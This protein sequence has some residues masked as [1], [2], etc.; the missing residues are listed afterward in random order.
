MLI[1]VIILTFN[2][3]LHIERCIASARDISD[4][5]YVIDSYSTDGTIRLAKDAGATVL[6]RNFDS[7]FDQFNWALTKIEPCEWVIRLDADEYFTPQLVESINLLRTLSDPNI[8][9]YAF[10]RRM[11]FLN[12]SIRFGGVF[13]IEIVRMFRFGNGSI[14]SRLMDEHIIVSG[15][16][17]TLLGEIIDDSKKSLN[18]WISKHNHYSSLEALE[19]LSENKVIDSNSKVNG[20]TAFRRQLKNIYLNFPI[21]VRA[22]CY[23]LYRYFIRCGFKDGFYGFLFHFYQGF[24][25]RLMVDSKIRLVLDFQDYKIRDASER[26]ISDI[27]ALPE[28][29]VKAKLSSVRKN[30][31]L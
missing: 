8:Y 5:V 10:Q 26:E 17:K 18:C 22:L 9:G 14:E 23:F 12:K 16:V 31:P 30:P 2:E 29:L 6:E 27:L 7:H 3:E 24:W 13:P 11:T 1:T 21:P 19:I 4:S 15:P 20:K 28:N 25:Y